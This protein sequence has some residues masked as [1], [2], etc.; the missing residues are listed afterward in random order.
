M[1]DDPKD[2]MPNLPDTERQILI[3]DDASLRSEVAADARE[4][5]EETRYI[6][7][8][9]FEDAG[10][11]AL[12]PPDRPR[13]VY[14]GMWG[15]VEI[16]AV[17]V[18]MLLMLA[19]IVFYVFF[20]I[21]S[22]RELEAER[23][24]RDR[25]ERELVSA[26]ERYGNITNV[27]TEVAR[28][29]E[30]VDS[31]E[32][33]Y[34]PLSVTGR[35]ALYQRVNGLI[36]AHGLVNTTGPDYSPLEVADQS[37][38]NQSDTERGRSKFRSHFPGIYVTMTVEGT[39]PSIRRFIRE[40][41]TG[42]EFVIISSVELEPAERRQQPAEIDQQTGTETASQENPGFP[43]GFGQPQTQTP[44][45]PATQRGRTLGEIVSL[46]I[47]MAAYFRRQNSHP[48]GTEDVQ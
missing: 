19:V 22:G 29:I 45:S 34:L 39:Y 5:F 32:S 7:V 14:A 11:T 28:L 16:A 31:F 35:T 15:T 3:D 33:R 27:E 2:T 47:E 9:A 26:K 8:A 17:G 13:K 43:G 41:E 38:T 23:M 42:N 1:S 30:S 4:G 36:S 10:S 40:I 46:R 18:S 44:R 21:P 37:V 48:V 24:E 12:V 25:V 20:V 6:E